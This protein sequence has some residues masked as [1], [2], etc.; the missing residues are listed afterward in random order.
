MVWCA[1]YGIAAPAAVPALIR[2]MAGA[3]AC[4]QLLDA[5][6]AWLFVAVYSYPFLVFLM[7]CRN[8]LQG[9]GR[10]SSLILLGF[11]EMLAKFATAW[12]L[13]PRLGYGAVCL[14]TAFIWAV[15]GLTGL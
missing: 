5:G 6:T 14:S 2:L 4:A 11:L 8:A 7:I 10:Y 9:M 1:L 12:V 3:G 13:I 15:P